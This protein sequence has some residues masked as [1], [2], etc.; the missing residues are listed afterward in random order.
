M[1]EIQSLKGVSDEYKGFH[2]KT[3]TPTCCGLSET[4]EKQY[5]RRNDQQ[6]DRNYCFD[7]Q[8][9]AATYDQLRRNKAGPR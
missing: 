3:Q 6:I 2:W 1:T 4:W 7:R 5:Y 8:G 9:K